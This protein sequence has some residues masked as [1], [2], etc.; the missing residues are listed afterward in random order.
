MMI[1]DDSSDEYLESY[2]GALRFTAVVVLRVSSSYQT[3][4]AFLW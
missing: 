3:C 4:S 2:I 1:I